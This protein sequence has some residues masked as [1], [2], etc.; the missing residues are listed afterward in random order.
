PASSILRLLNM[1]LYYILF[2]PFCA[3][4]TGYQFI[5]GAWYLFDLNSGA[6]WTNMV[7][8]NGMVADANGVLH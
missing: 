4:K 5:D 7:T 6:L 2:L 8:P 3:R 1:I